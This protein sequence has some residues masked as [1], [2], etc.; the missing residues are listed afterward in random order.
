MKFSVLAIAAA[1]A[2]A[3]AKSVA[4]SPGPDVGG[5]ECD[6]CKAA[7]PAIDKYLTKEIP[8]LTKYLEDVCKLLPS[9]DQGVVH[10]PGFTRS[11]QHPM[12]TRRRKAVPFLGSW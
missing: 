2:T 10:P 12:E 11:P 9:A 5:I 8:T 4:V 7:I 1:F 6:L 3:S